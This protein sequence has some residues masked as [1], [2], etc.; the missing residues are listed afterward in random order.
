MLIDDS[1]PIIYLY[2]QLFNRPFQKSKNCNHFGHLHRI[3]PSNESD[4]AVDVY[5]N[6]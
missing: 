4:I 1:V 5:E 3:G 2:H 6:D